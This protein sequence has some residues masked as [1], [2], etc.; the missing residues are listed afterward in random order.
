MFEIVSD[1]HPRYDIVFSKISVAVPTHFFGNYYMH[2]REER[3]EEP[4]E[5]APTD[6]ASPEFPKTKSYQ[7]RA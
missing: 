3:Q 7:L 2:K 4:V 5:R 1:F 6:V